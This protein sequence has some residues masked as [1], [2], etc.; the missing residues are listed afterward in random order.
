MKAAESI[1][2]DRGCSVAQVAVA[3][4]SSFDF[5]VF[6]VVTV[7]SDKRMKEIVEASDIKLTEEDIR[8]LK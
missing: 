4:F 2:A 1:A 6:P 7:S 8:R 3:W 5:N